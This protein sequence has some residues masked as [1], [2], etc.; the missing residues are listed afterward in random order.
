MHYKFPECGGTDGCPTCYGLPCNFK[1]NRKN[2]LEQT[3]MIL[4]GKTDVED[5][6][7]CYFAYAVLLVYAFIVL[8]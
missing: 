5:K 2:L 8:T 6:V 3:N 4:D 1:A 7:H